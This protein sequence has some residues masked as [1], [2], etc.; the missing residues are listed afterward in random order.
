M[1]DP[2]QDTQGPWPARHVRFQRKGGRSHTVAREYI[3]LEACSGIK[4][5]RSDHRLLISLVDTGA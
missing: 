3:G 5:A 4:L 2:L 1:L